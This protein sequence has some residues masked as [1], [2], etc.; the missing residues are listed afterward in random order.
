MFLPRPYGREL[1]VGQ[2]SELRVLDVDGGASRLVYSTEFLIEAPNWMPDGKTLVFNAGGEIWKLSLS[3][4]E[5]QRIDTGPLQD[6]NNDHVVSPDGRFLYLSSDDGHLY[7]V[8]VAG[9]NPVRISN[10]HAAPFHYYLHGI[11]PDGRELAFVAL[12]KD[13]TRTRANIFTIPADGGLDRRLT[14]MAEP[15]D[16]PEFAPDGKWIY[17]NSERAARRPG[18]AQIFRMARDG[19]RLSQLTSDERVNWFP[20]ISPDGKNIVY[21]SYP[22]DTTGHPADCDVILRLMQISGGGKRD[23]A[24][25][26]GGQGTIN[27]N[28][29]SPDSRSIAFVMFPFCTAPSCLRLP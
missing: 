13:G 5:P 23:L 12:E 3:G 2:R 7:R 27:V 6:L 24:R 15:C 11:S 20:H 8:P 26:N 29:W 16:G 17:F 19:S 10:A 14:D 22:P 28:S 1:A 21:L 18:H 4:G 25:F 9:G